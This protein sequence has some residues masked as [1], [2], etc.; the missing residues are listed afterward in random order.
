LVSVTPPGPAGA[1]AET[2]PVFVHAD[3][4]VGP[5][6]AGYP[7]EWRTRTQ[8]FRAYC[9]EGG[10]CGGEIVEPGDQQEQIA[11]RLLAQ[12]GVAFVQSRNVVYGC[13]MLTMRRSDESF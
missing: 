6:T 8:I 7:D 9:E 5:A 12:P 3:A 1:Y 13:Y 2:G 4:C 11:E 10:I